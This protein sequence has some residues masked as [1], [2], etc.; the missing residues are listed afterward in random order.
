MQ[1]GFLVLKR[2]GTEYA[3]EL[4][5]VEYVHYNAI[6]IVLLWLVLFAVWTIVGS[7]KPV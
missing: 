7:T 4:R 3:F 1:L 2:L 6:W 5:I